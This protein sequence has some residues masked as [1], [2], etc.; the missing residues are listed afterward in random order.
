MPSRIRIAL[1]LSLGLLGISLGSILVRF[2]QEA[3]SLTIAF[4]RM[5]LATLFFLP[6]YLGRKD[7]RRVSGRVTL[8]AGLALALHFACWIAS[9][10]FTS[11]AVS[12]LLLSTSPVLVALL[13]YV[14]YRERLSR[15]GMAG[16]ALTVLGSGLLV[17]NDLSL[18]EDWRGPLLALLGGLAYAVY[19][20]VGRGA[21]QGMTL[22]EYVVP[23]YATAAAL[24]ALMVM[25][26]GTPFFGFRPDT[27]LFLVLLALLPQCLGHTAYNWSLKYLTATLVA[28]LA[29]A[30]PVTASAL[31]YWILSEPLPSMVLAG[32]AAVGTGILL[33]ARWGSGGMLQDSENQE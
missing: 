17:C 6:F 26:S 30:E 27:Y 8:G 1:I 7:R 20:V 23:V 32:G 15:L 16:V 5:F 29:L 11:V 21:R 19:F 12:V 3:P 9:L 31:A 28:V 18:I 14:L 2:S 13:S 33:V 22:L 25:V 24:L 10:R 4:Y